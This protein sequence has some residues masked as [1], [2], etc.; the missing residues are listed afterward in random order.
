MYLGRFAKEVKESMTSTSETAEKPK[1]KPKSKPKS[2][3]Q[4]KEEEDARAR[5]EQLQSVIKKKAEEA[6]EA[7]TQ[8]LLKDELTRRKQLHNRT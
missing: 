4:I 2:K 1:L 8:N 3:G 7:K 5:T 6:E